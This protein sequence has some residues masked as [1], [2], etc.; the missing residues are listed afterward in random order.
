MSQLL[1]VSDLQTHFPT[2]AGLVRSVDGVSFEL[3]PGETLPLARKR[4]NA[5]SAGSACVSPDTRSR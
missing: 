4:R 5:I 1:E 3:Q 2:R